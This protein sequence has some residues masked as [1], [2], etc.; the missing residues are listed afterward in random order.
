MRDAKKETPLE[1]IG[2]SPKPVRGKIRLLARWSKFALWSLSEGHFDFF[3]NAFSALLLL[4]FF[5]LRDIILMQKNVTCNIC[6][7]SGYSFYPNICAGYYDKKVLCPGC[8]CLDRYRTYAAILK[9]CT[10]YFS[11]DTF[12]IEVAPVRRFQEYCLRNKNNKNYISFDI[13][14]FAMEKGDITNMRYEDDTTDYFLCSEVLD[15]ITDDDAAFREVWRVLKPGG[16]LVF[17]V[18]VDWDVA[19]TREYG[20]PDPKDDF[21]IRRYGRDVFQRISAFGFEVYKLTA[22]ECVGEQEIK[23]FGLCREPLFFARK[24]ARH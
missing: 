9:R 2:I 22:A 21:H 13:Q 8:D 3:W 20:A 14:R 6:G 24:V 15:Y 1:L 4:V 18:G 10:D 16:L 11:P 17:R 23:K 5:S 19:E 7:W 12:V